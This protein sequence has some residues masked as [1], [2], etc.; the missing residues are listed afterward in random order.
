MT[1]E[2]TYSNRLRYLT[3]LSVDTSKMLIFECAQDANSK[4]LDVFE[5]TK[6]MVKYFGLSLY[7]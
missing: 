3:I 5:R 2:L 1:V 7:I 4:H 6:N